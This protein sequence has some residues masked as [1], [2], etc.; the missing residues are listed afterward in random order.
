MDSLVLPHVNT[1]CMQLFLD[2]VAARY[3]AE[4]IVMVM[5]GAG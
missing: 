4:N 1:D 2:E 5:D 3:P